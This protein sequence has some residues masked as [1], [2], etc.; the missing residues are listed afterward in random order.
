MIEYMGAICWINHGKKFYLMA[1]NKTEPVLIVLAQ[2]NNT[3]QESHVTSFGPCVLLSQ[4]V[5][6]FTPKSFTFNGEANQIPILKFNTLREKYFK[7][8]KIGDNTK[9]VSQTVET[10]IS[11]KILPSNQVCLLWTR[12]KCLV[13]RDTCLEFSKRN[14]WEWRVGS[15]PQGNRASIIC[16]ACMQHVCGLYCSHHPLVEQA[17]H[18]CISWLLLTQ[19]HPIL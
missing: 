12:H 9:S 14:S 18:F 8:K 11:N 6:A 3:R 2:Y 15:Q 16:T 1:Y 13:D 10:F 17:H 4:A 7:A 19:V 5:F